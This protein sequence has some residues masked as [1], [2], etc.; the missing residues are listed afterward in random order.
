MATITRVNFEPVSDLNTV[1]RRNHQLSDRSLI[2]PYNKDCLVDG[3]W[4]TFDPASKKVIKLKRATD[5]S[6]LHQVTDSMAWPLFNEQGRTDTQATGHV[7]ILFMGQYEFDTR[8]FDATAAS[9]VAIDK[10]LQPLKV[11]T[12]QSDPSGTRRF[13]GLVGASYDDSDPIVGYAT[14]LPQYNGGKLRFINGWAVN[15]G[16][17]VAGGG[18]PALP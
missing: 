4:L 1:A 14:R 7:T 6:V 18:G 10:L 2:H 17:V 3:E 15:N 12:I 5:I 9:G 13:S 16:A 8:I 11:A